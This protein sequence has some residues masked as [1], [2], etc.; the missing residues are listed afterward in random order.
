[1]RAGRLSTRCRC[2]TISS[3]GI[4]TTWKGTIKVARI[5]MKATCEPGNRS[6]A[7]A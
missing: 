4:I 3:V 7:K 5:A 6:R 1:M 2:L